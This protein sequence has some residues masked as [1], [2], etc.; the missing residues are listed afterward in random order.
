MIYFLILFFFSPSIQARLVN[1]DEL[2]QRIAYITATDIYYRIQ[3]HCFFEPLKKKT[4]FCKQIEDYSEQKQDIA[5]IQNIIT[6]NV[7]S[8][9]STYELTVISDF[10]A[11]GYYNPLVRMASPKFATQLILSEI[12]ENPSDEYLLEFFE[13]NAI[14]LQAYKRAFDFMHTPIGAKFVEFYTSESLFNF[15]NQEF[16]AGR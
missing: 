2:E 11:H 7:A 14:E 1:T 6:P 9:F 16:K 13:G 15:A 10:F 4:K 3:F 8:T 12:T 5:K